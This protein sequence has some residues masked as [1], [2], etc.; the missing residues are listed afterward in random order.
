MELGLP[1]ANRALTFVFST[2]VAVA[3]CR[4]EVPRRS[5]GRGSG[6]RAVLQPGP[7]TTEERGEE[8]YYQKIKSFYFFMIKI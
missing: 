6:A 7:L 3:V 1:S 4:A 2:V 8:N 5:L